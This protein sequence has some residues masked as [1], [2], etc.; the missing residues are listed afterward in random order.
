MSFIL[1]GN[2]PEGTAGS[3]SDSL[4]VDLSNCFL[5]ELHHFTL[6]SAMDEDSNYSQNTILLTE[7]KLEWDLNFLVVLFLK[8]YP[9]KTAQSI[10]FLTHVLFPSMWYVINLVFVWLHF[11]WF[12]LYLIEF[13]EY[14][15]H[16]HGSRVKTI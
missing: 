1:L 7:I 11:Q 15:N 4:S 8:L 13:F 14:K 5:E 3:Y 12:P 16:F 10:V 2:N 6:P 9:T